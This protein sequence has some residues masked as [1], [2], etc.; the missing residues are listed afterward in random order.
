MEA[1]IKDLKDSF[2]VG[3]EAYQDSRNESNETWDLYHNRHYT[4]EQLAILEARGQPAETFNVV[5]MFARMLVGYY[6]TVVNTV[7]AAPRHMDDTTTAAALNA[8]IDKVFELNDFDTEGDKIKLGGLLSGLLISYTDV[9]DTGERDA[10]NRPINQVVCHHVPDAQV[11][12]DPSSTADDYS[13]ARWL[14][15]FKWMTEDAVAKAFGKEALEKLQAYDNYLDIDE[16]EFDA[17]FTSPFSGYYRIFDNYLVV[18]TVLVDSDGERWSCFWSGDELLEKK[19]ITYKKTKW[20]YR[21]QRLHDSEKKEYYGVFRDI[22]ESQHALNQAILKIQQMV[23]SSK[24]FVE[25][26]SVDDIA[27]FTAMYNRVNAVIPVKSLKG[28]R[29][30][31]LAK[32]VQDQYIIIDSALNRIQRVLGINESFLGQAFASDSGRKVKLQQNQTIMSL[33][34]F[35]QRIESF[36][37]KLGWDVAHLIQ[38]YYTATYVFN[39]MDP[40]V[41]DS[42]MEL[43]KPISKPTGEIDQL[44]GEPIMVPVLLP[45]FDPASGMPME[46]EDGN[47]ILAPVPEPGTEIAFTRFEIRMESNAYNDEDE[48]AQLMLESVMSGQIGQVLSQANPADYLRVAALILKSTKTKYSPAI[49]AIIEKTAAQ[50]GGDVETSS[51]IQNRGASQQQPQQGPMSRS[52]KLPTNTN[53]GA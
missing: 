36:Y 12:L 50:L 5:K 14:H 3:Y 47:I 16:A 27:S 7:I 42:W 13:D 22:K 32:E 10:F 24:A 19:L 38:Q 46:D 52:L 51:A 30:E 41:G 40:V 2:K 35:T 31:Q 4:S 9:E 43:N 44:T 21:V 37:K 6:S 45:M 49:S 48:K 39:C 18:H 15:R 17:N 25:T 11:V 34:Y 1:N 29:I 20:H 26:G 53:E 23:N 33:R 28:I 8:T